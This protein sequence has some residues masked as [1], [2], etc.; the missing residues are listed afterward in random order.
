MCKPKHHSFIV[1]CIVFLLLLC[2]G[3]VHAQVLIDSVIAVVSGKA[4][5]QSELV[6]EFRIKTIT[7]KLLSNEP[8]EEEKRESLER[9]INRKFVIQAAENIGITAVDHKKQVAERIAALGAKFPSDTAFRNILAKQDLE[10]DALKKWVYERLIYDE[11]YRRQFVN[12]VSSKEVD[13]FAPKYFEENK[14]LFIAPATVIFKAMLIT[15]KEDS[16]EKEKQAAKQLADQIN[17]RLQ[18]GETIEEVQQSLKNQDA[19]RFNSQTL[20][21]DTPLGANVAELKPTER[22]GPISVPEGFLIVELIKKTPQ[23]Q[24]QYSEV[25]SEIANMLRQNKAETAFKEW[26]YKKKSVELWYILDDALK[27]VSRIVI[28]PEK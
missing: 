13:D 9:I 7:D 24:K 20:A 19:I 2:G 3:H 21:A 12:K 28:Q 16:S 26:L 14:A 10:I 22:K 4:I 6:D 27:R 1:Q 5:T 25:K 23:R 11:Y 18:Q 15:V 17:L 8:N